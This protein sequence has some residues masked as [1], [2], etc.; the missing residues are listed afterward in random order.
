LANLGLLGQKWLSQRIKNKQYGDILDIYQQDVDNKK[1]VIKALYNNSSTTP[2]TD[3]KSPTN[4]PGLDMS[5][6]DLKYGDNTINK[7]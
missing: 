2:S 3:T 4:T 7:L 1:D 5:V 6:M